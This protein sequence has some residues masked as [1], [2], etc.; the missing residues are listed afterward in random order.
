MNCVFSSNKEFLNMKS[1]YELPFTM[2]LVTKQRVK[3]LIPSGYVDC[4]SSVYE[5]LRNVLNSQPATEGE[6]FSC[7]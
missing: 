5:I 7:I 4:F 2:E 6:I 1:E 3:G